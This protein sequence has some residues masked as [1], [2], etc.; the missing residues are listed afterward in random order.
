MDNFRHFEMILLIDYYIKIYFYCR[1]FIKISLYKIIS[2][3]TVLGY[4]LN[5]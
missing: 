3:I 1:V 2:V 5:T 4:N